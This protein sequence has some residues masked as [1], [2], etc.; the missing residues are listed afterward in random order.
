ME[1][2]YGAHTVFKMQVHL[3]WVTK[4]RKLVLGGEVG[5][6]VREIIR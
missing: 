5:V 6:M 4:Y 1:Y 3:V 2:R